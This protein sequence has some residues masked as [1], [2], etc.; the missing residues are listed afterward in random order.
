MCK[1]D[2]IYVVLHSATYL[3]SPSPPA[4]DFSI[5]SMT[6]NHHK[7][8]LPQLSPAIPLPKFD[9]PSERERDAWAFQP[10][11]EERTRTADPRNANGRRREHEER[12]RE[13]ESAKAREDLA[14]DR[15]ADNAR[16]ENKTK[17][18]QI[19]FQRA[20]LSSPNQDRKPRH[21]KKGSE[22]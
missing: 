15:E 13:R 19:S 10:R 20:S 16:P 21:E 3:W 22:D 8:D 7:E 11:H 5:W 18:N 17:T 2:S 9:F 12:E 4:I 14:A 6:K 1:T